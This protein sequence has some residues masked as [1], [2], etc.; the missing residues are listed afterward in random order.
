MKRLRPGGRIINL[1]SSVIGLALPGY[2]P[3]GASKAAVETLSN[4]FAKELRGKDLTVA[5]IAPG[6]TVTELFFQDKSE[7]EMNRLAKL[8]PLERLG[9]PEDI[10]AVVSF[11][12]GPEGD[13]INGQTIRANGGMV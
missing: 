9:R 2:V 12:V 13:W 5:A 7:E 3:Y 8:P 11:P 4:I 1:S 10:A 6:P